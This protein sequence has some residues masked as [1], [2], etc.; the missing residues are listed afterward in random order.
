[1]AVV[2]GPDVAPV[3]APDDKAGGD[4]A[5]RRAERERAHGRIANHATLMK[6]AP[7]WEPLSWNLACRPSRTTPTTPRLAPPNLPRHT[8]PEQTPSPRDE[9]APIVALGTTKNE[10]IIL[11]GARRFRVSDVRRGADDHAEP[12]AGAVESGI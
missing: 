3:A 1:V 2:H 11:V 12:R 9:G 7:A 6:K 5:R 10:K 4:R 8:V